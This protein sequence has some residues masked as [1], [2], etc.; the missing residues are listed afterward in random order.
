MQKG[1]SEP[2]S[3]SSRAL[4]G[5]PDRPYRSGRPYL[6]VSNW[7]RSKER[8]PALDT[9]KIF[10]PAAAAPAG[11]LTGGLADTGARWRPLRGSSRSRHGLEGPLAYVHPCVSCVPVDL[12]V[13]SLRCYRLV[14][15]PVK[16][17]LDRNFRCTVT[18]Y[19][20][21]P[22]SMRKPRAKSVNGSRARVHTDQGNL[23][24]V[25]PV[26]MSEGLAARLRAADVTA[27]KV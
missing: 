8:V 14:L 13:L 11:P 3:G 21:V 24:L 10:K 17:M 16:A 1:S 2:V 12:Y 4:C 18:E 15:R 19:M 7:A 20:L 25:Q 26:C 6:L 5:R 22:C 9:T 23:W 27:A